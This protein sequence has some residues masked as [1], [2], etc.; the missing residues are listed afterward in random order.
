M[1][2]FYSIL[3]TSLISL[4]LNA[5]Q[6]YNMSLLGKLDY[7][8]GLN[9]VWGYVD[10]DKGEYAIVG[11]VN[12]ISIVDVTDPSI[13]IEKAFIPGPTSI[14]RDIKTYGRYAYVVHDS[15]TEGESQGLLIIDLSNIADG[16]ISYSSILD[17]SY[18]R[19]HNLFIDENGIAYLF[20]GN[21]DN[22]GVLFYDL[23]PNPLIPFYLGE[24]EEFYLHDGMVR[25]D[26]LW[27]S[28]IFDGL[29]LAIDVSNKSNPNLIGSVSTPNN[30]THNAWVSD[31]GNSV[32][33]TDEVAGA[34]IAAVDVSDVSNMTVIDQIQSWSPETNVIPH[35]THVHGK[36]LVTSYYCDGVTVVDSSD[37][38][39]L[40]GVAYYDTSDSTGGTFS[41]AWGAYPWLPSGN[42]L[43]SDRQEGLHVLSVDNLEFSSD[44]LDELLD[45]KISSNPTN[46]QFIVNLNNKFKL[47][48][49]SLDGRLIDIIE[50]SSSSANLAI[51]SSWNAGTYILK[52]SNSNGL[53]VSYKL[54]KTSL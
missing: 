8:Q 19:F 7:Q 5:Q 24:Y 46:D 6:S 18:S 10:E 17:V 27:G 3:F 9:D 13:L 25:G 47:E 37:P 33:T 4:S 26:T 53:S 2:L 41:G 38:T 50:S 34:Y 29:L 20:G 44:D 43:V 51:G 22:G 28:A 48:V 42:I 45:V 32:F 14:W 12:G 1:K 39:N 15:F 21:Y 16:N 11:L 49:F 35:N 40:Q 52:V 31:D 23:N 30:F 36:Y 54:I